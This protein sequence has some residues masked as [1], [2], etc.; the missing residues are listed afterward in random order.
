MDGFDHGLLMIQPNTRSTVY[1]TVG[2][3]GLDVLNIPAVAAIAHAA[4]LPLMNMRRPPR[5]IYR[6]QA[7]NKA[8]IVMH[9]A[10]KFPLS[11]T[12]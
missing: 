10:T 8:D 5:R 1:E 4:G 3:P 7:Y 11:G 2:N 12:A 6:A 9:P